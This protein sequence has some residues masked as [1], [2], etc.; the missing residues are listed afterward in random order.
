MRFQRLSYLCLFAACCWQLLPAR[1][2]LAQEAM[3]D[4]DPLY[5]AVLT[6]WG[7]GDT[8]GAEAELAKV[9]PGTLISEKTALL[10][11]IMILGRGFVSPEPSLQE[12]ITIAPES[13]EAK[14]A[15]HLSNILKKN[16][17]ERNVKELVQLVERNPGRPVL[18]FAAI[19]ALQ[20]RK[21]EV[22][23]EAWCIRVASMV[24]PGPPPLHLRWGSAL[25]AQKKHEEALVH[26]KLALQ[27]EPAAWSNAALGF[28]LD[29]LQRYDE[30]NNAYAEAIRIYPAPEHYVSWGISRSH[31]GEYAEAL[32][33]FE[34]ALKRDPRSLL[35]MRWRA[36]T[37]ERVGRWDEALNE[38]A[39]VRKLSTDDRYAYVSAIELLRSLGRDQ[40][41]AA[42]AA[43]WISA[44]NTAPLSL[45]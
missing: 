26:R 20:S 32:E 2:L 23:A 36:K 10:K 19:V 18:A 3:E 14:V 43:E 33:K 44:G 37:L 22:A 45:N 31:A 42:I 17:E 38:Y 21:D 40:D 1:G 35:A 27:L 9:L 24:K 6:R 34:L 25:D 11:A 30:A 12:V 29:S 8:K 5:T 15:S 7:S 28:T 39:A 13:V 41:V 4:G 16:E